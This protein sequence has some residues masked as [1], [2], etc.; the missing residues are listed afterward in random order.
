MASVNI[1]ILLG[2]LTRD[3][4]MKF[5]QNGTAVASFGLACNRKFNDAQ[6]QSREEVL[7]IDCAAFGKPAEIIN[8]YCHKGDLLHITGRLKLDTWEDKQGGGKRSKI[9]VNVDNFQLMPNKRDGD[10]GAQ[11]GGQ[12]PPRTAAP[13]RTGPPTNQPGRAAP[14]PQQTQGEFP[15]DDPQFKEDDI[16]F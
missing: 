3:V 6:G 16:P 14:A 1:V 12:T 11:S 5:L 2:N 10:N 4:E 7:F 9:N 13:T 8:Q 15:E